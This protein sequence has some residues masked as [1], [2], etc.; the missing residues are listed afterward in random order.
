MMK[1][2]ARK[3]TVDPFD[4]Q[5]STT[6]RGSFVDLNTELTVRDLGRV[7][8]VA[9]VTSPAGKQWID[10]ID[11]DGQWR[12]AHVCQVVRVHRTSRLRGAM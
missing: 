9:L 2:T 12:S 10:V 6:L 3:P 8:F 7:R 5:R 11:R 1:V 4:R